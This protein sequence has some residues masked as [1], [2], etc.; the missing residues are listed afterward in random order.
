[1]A[2]LATAPHL[3]PFQSRLARLLRS[4]GFFVLVVQ[5]I[6]ATAIVVP[7]FYA[8]YYSQTFRDVFF[9]VRFDFIREGTPNQKVLLYLGN[10]SKIEMGNKLMSVGDD[11]TT[12]CITYFYQ[13]DTYTYNKILMED[14]KVIQKVQN[15]YW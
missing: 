14:G 15:E 9:D 7:G 13:T 6:I 8:V 4:Q 1:V 10:P 11:K 2:A 5:L 12:R 3:H